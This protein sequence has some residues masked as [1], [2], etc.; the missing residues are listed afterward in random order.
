[1]ALPELMTIEDVMKYLRKSRTTVYKLLREGD[2]KG[3]K[4]GRDWR[5]KKD[6]LQEYVNQDE[7]QQR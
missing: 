1:M 6:D 7:T 5:V 3:I 2:L 4:V